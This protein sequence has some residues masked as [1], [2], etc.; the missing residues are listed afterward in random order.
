MP[1]IADMNSQA[2]PMAAA[3][4]AARHSHVALARSRGAGGGR[5]GG[6]GRRRGSPF[7]AL[8]DVHKPAR[9]YFPPPTGRGGGEVFTLRPA[10]F[11]WPVPLTP[12][13]AD[14]EHSTHSKQDVPAPSVNPLS[15]K[16]PNVQPVEQEPEQEHEQ[17]SVRATAGKSF[18]AATRSLSGSRKKASH[19]RRVTWSGTDHTKEIARTPSSLVFSPD[20]HAIEIAKHLA[21]LADEPELRRAVEAVV[22]VRRQAA[23]IVRSLSARDEWSGSLE[24]VE[25]ACRLWTWREGAYMREMDELARCVVSLRAS[26]RSRGGGEDD[27]DVWRL[28]AAYR[29]ARRRMDDAE[30]D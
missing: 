8:A 19:R 3:S 23:G 6:R 10:S 28:K 18:V 24:G 12:A 30:S 7:A 27:D 25:E 20:L 17:L 4:L 29:A 22:H 14:R 5:S 16:D 1:V 15:T 2:V 11:T 13:S 26:G 21:T 9:A